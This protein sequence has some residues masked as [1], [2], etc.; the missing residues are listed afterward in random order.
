MLDR[1]AGSKERLAKANQLSR[2]QATAG[3]ALPPP[4]AAIKHPRPG[5]TDAPGAKRARLNTSTSLPLPPPPPPSASAVPL[6]LPP[7]APQIPVPVI[8]INDGQPPS[9]VP[10]LTPPAPDI[11]PAQEFLASVTNPEAT[12]VTVQVPKDPSSKWNFDGRAISVT[13]DITTATIKLLKESLRSEL[14]DMPVNRIQLRL[15][16]GGFLKDK[17]DLAS[18][19]IGPG[20]TLNLVQKTRGG[21]GRK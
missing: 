12:L 15:P 14:G 6:P 20:S 5:G 7:P 4:P 10:E 9:R 17:D 21:G 16:G 1:E 8:K 2:E 19:N 3:A 11:L 18:L 13:V